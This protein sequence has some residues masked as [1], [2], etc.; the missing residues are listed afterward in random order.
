MKIYEEWRAH[1]PKE[2]DRIDGEEEPRNGSVIK[3]VE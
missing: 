2:Y 1:L 3:V